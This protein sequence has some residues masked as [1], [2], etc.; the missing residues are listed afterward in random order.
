MTDG[1]RN[2]LTAAVAAALLCGCGTRRTTDTPRTASEQLLVSAA[3]DQAVGQLNYQPLED[4]KVFVDSEL[5]D[6]VD[7][8]FVVAAIRARCFDAGAQV[9]SDVEQADYILEIRSGAVGVDRTEYIFGIPAGEIPS[10]FGAMPIP[11]A[12][13]FKSIRQRGATR[14]SF[15]VFRRDDRRLLYASGPA[16][17]FSNQRNW[18]LFGGGP[19]VKDNIKPPPS[20]QNTATVRDP[21]GETLASPPELDEAGATGTGGGQK[22]VEME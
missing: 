7:K 16:F 6:R 10:P 19:V 4:R 9:V 3:V 1:I 5:L 15:V 2:A 20:E 12:A 18:W 21:A 17:G 13:L 11:E 8:T 22:T 14:V